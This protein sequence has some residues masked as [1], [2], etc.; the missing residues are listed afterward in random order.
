M[1]FT[2]TQNFT[3]AEVACKCGCGFLPEQDFMERVQRLRDALRFPLTVSS[4]ARCP[5]YNDKESKT[6][7]D[8]PHTTGR[9]IDLVVRGDQAL[10]VLEAMLREGF[11]GIGVN[12]KGDARFIHGDDLPNKP[13]QPRPHLWSY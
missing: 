2:G 10:S 8:G 5:D 13:G 11:T 6:G 3:P 12:Q 1:R 7:R 4:A 9:A